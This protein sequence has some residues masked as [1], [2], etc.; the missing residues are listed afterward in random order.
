MY[1]LVHVGINGLIKTALRFR[2]PNIIFSTLD[3]GYA[4]KIAK[5][6]TYYVHNRYFLFSIDINIIVYIDSVIILCGPSVTFV[7]IS[8]SLK[9][10]LGGC[11]RCPDNHDLSKCHRLYDLGRYI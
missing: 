10:V 8:N 7:L 6:I 1:V 4:L 11:P 3:K 2:P 5:R 9:V